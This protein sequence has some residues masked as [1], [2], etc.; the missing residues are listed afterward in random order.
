MLQVDCEKISSVTCSGK[1]K[2]D[3][4]VSMTLTD[5][6]T[7]RG[8]IHLKKKKTKI[9]TRMADVRTIDNLICPDWTS[10]GACSVTCGG[11]TQTRTNR[12]CPD[13][14]HK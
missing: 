8:D 10:W 3:E 13:D 12:N 2:N 14:F 4:G 1:Y 5:T 6:F 9:A 7:F 11:G